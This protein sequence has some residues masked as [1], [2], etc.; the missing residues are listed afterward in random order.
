MRA[1]ITNAVSVA[2]GVAAAL[3]IAGRRRWL[4]RPHTTISHC[5]I[6]GPAILNDD[7][8]LVIDGRVAGSDPT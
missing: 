2:T 4:P 5:T 8:G 7:Q 3:W 1:A 6:T